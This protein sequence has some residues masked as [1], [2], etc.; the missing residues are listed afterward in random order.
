MAIDHLHG[1]RVGYI[2]P[3]TLFLNAVAVFF[4]FSAAT[5]VQLTSLVAQESNAPWITPMIEK[6]AAQLGVTPAIALE[7]AERRFQ[8]VYTLCLAVVSGIGYT[9]VF[10]WLYRRSLPGWRGAFTLAL[11]YLAF[12]FTLFLPWL[13]VI[14]PLRPRYGEVTMQGVLIAGL[15][16]CAWW[17]AAA[18]R[19]IGG[20]GWPMAIGKSLFVIACGTVIDTTMSALAIVLTLRLA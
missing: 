14:A 12:L 19:R 3:L 18:A 11:Y 10:R 1:A 9:L 15:V 6:R 2:P 13:L 8:S 4:L 17:N 16:V 7:R 5:Q 20:H